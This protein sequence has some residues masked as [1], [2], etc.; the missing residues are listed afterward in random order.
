MNCSGLM[1][2][3]V[4]IREPVLIMLPG[5]VEI[6]NWLATIMVPLPVR[7]PRMSLGLPPKTRLRAIEAALG[8]LKWVCSPAAMLKLC[9]LTA[10]RSVVWF[11]VRLAPSR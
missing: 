9:Q 11:T 7:V 10:S 8:M 6:P 4:R 3:V 2:F 1:S 5:A